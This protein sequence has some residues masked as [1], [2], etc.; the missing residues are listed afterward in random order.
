M[1]NERITEYVQKMFSKLPRTK[2][3]IDIKQN[4]LESMEDGYAEY[5]DKGYSEEDAYNKVVE[6]FGN[7]DEVK[8]ALGIGQ[9][10]QN[11]YFVSQSGDEE[12]YEYEETED[13]GKEPRIKKSKL[14]KSIIAVVMPLSV[15]IYLIAGL[16]GAWDPFWLVF[17][18]FGISCGILSVAFDLYN[19]KRDGVLTKRRIGWFVGSVCILSAVI[20]YLLIGYLSNGWHPWWV[21]IPAVALLSWGLD[22]VF[23]F[24]DCGDNQR[25]KVSALSGLI[26][27]TATVIFLL[28]GAIFN[29]WHPTWIVFPIGGVATSIVNIIFEARKGE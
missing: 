8:A 22:L 11:E 16:F 27:L 21:L 10:T 2:E 23:E 17:P 29:L 7:I 14:Q 9:D 15:V 4:I 6:R 24:A 18:V 26:M 5:L 3:A 13:Y 25:K 1:Q 28:S 19:Y 20:A 12:G